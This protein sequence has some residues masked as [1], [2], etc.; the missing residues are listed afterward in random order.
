MSKKPKKRSRK[1]ALDRPFDLA[2]LKQAREIATQYTVILQPDPEL[3]YFGRGLEMPYA[4]GD[5]KTPD[6]CVGQT[7]EAFI[8]A[9]ATMLEKKETPP[10]PA[11]EARRQEQVN[12][13]VTAEEKLLLEQ[14]ARSKG[15]RSV[16]DFVRSASLASVQ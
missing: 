5:G 15:Y 14:G 2:I 9:V 13:R 8:A 6:E 16:S 12:V 11:S 7:R 4:M 3:G 10:A 1:L